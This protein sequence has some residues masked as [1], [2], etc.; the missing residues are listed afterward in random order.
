MQKS[1][2]SAKKVVKKSKKTKKT[3]K[4]NQS[5]DYIPFYAKVDK[6]IDATPL[7]KPKQT[8]NPLALPVTVLP[9]NHPY[10]RVVGL[11]LTDYAQYKYLGGDG[12]ND[13]WIQKSQH[14]NIPKNYRP[15]LTTQPVNI[16]PTV[17]GTLKKKAFTAAYKKKIGTK[18][19]EDEY[20]IFE[21]GVL[22]PTGFK[23]EK[24]IWPK[25]YQN[26]Y[27]YQDFIYLQDIYANTIAGRIID[28]AVYFMLAN[29]VKPKIRVKYES[30]FKT[31]EDKRKFIKEHQWMVDTLE[32]IDK[33]VST[34]SMPKAFGEED[35]DDGI[36]NIGPL[37][38]AKDKD[39]ATYD[40]SLQKKW[41]S[42]CVQALTFG[43]NC[44]VP[45]VDPE[46]NIVKIMEDGK[47]VEFKN[48]PKI[49]L[50]IY[51]RDMGFN[52]VDYITHRLLGI[53]LNNSN[54]ILKPDEMIFWENKPD[55]PTYGS[56]YYGMAELQSMMGSARTIRQ[57]VEVD[58]PLISQTRWSGMYWIVMKRKFE[59]AGTSDVEG[60]AILANIELNGIN[61]S[62]EDNPAEDFIIH[63][64]DLDPKI[65]ELLQTVKDLTQNMQGQVGLPQG[66]L[67]GEQDL[68]RDT[69]SKK[70]S[71]WD[72]TYIKD[73]RKWFLEPVTEQW[74][75]RLAKTLE[76]QSEK[77]K[78]A[79]KR[80][81]VYA[82]VEP[83]RLEDLQ[84]QI[85][86]LMTME[87]VTG[88]WTD[89]A[90]AEFLDMEDLPDMIDP[91]KGP[92]DVPPM[93]GGGQ[94]NMKITEEGSNRSFGVQNQD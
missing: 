22:K 88:A 48:I 12:I 21:G 42:A 55:N 36:P 79:L 69:L 45:R 60:A 11:S 28:A 3:K 2:K 38:R 75:K 33:H 13:P 57:I 54:W 29:G 94:G 52:Y 78:E 24:I 89:E 15:Y 92:E 59:D 49:I 46:D 32:A 63:K 70:I 72:K 31:D 77:W 34:S 66:I 10:R 8:D 39:T 65:G 19:W 30:E 47:E 5:I 93:P 20:K 9:P 82:D 40:T 27:Q 71:T 74:Y 50:P 85:Q 6:I 61:I 35:T 25:F 86:V 58:L 87:N 73:K 37:G 51:T 80:I 41:K 44:I 81:E 62:M 56:K 26:P 16:V 17:D 64:I 18:G 83:L 43:R 4:N 7:P 84:N 67:V 23:Q 91:D 53:Q 76:K 14:V 90:R 1:S 68:N